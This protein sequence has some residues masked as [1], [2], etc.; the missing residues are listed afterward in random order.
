MSIEQDNVDDG[1]GEAQLGPPP[2]DARDA[3]IRELEARIAA[4]GDVEL[5]L[6][7]SEERLHQLLAERGHEEASVRTSEQQLSSIVESIVDGCFTLDGELRFVHINDAALSRLGRPRAAVIGRK[8]TE[9]IPPI[10]GSV[11][12]REYLAA[13]RTDKPAHFEAPATYL[14]AILAVHVYPARGQL[15]VLFQ[16]VSDRRR[17]ESDLREGERRFR[18]VFDNA[19][20]AIVLTDPSD[21]TGGV[22]DVNPAACRMFGYSADE[23]R[24]LRRDDI[25]DPADPATLVMLEERRQTGNASAV[26]RYKRKD[27]TIFAGEL[28][29]SLF[30]DQAGRTQNVSIIRDVSDR[31]AAERNE[32]QAHQRILEI[33]ESIGDGFLS[34]DHAWRFTFI[35]RRGAKRGGKEPNEVIGGNLWEFLPDIVGTE[36]ERSYR[37]AM[38]ER[39]PVCFE[40]HDV[41]SDTWYSTSVYPSH[42]GITMLWRDISAQKR[43]E[44]ELRHALA[45]AEEGQRTLEALMDSIPEGITIADANGPT[46]RMVSR[47]GQQLLGAP[48]AEMTTS[49]ITRR[50]TVYPVDDERPMRPEELPLVRAIRDGE[51]VRDAELIQKTVDGQRLRLSCNAAPIRDGKGRTLGGV[52]AWRDVTAERAS[53][54]ALRVSEQRYRDLFNSMTEGFAVHE[55]LCDAKGSPVDFRF[56]EI[57]PAF[58]RLTGLGRDIVGKTHNQV[59]PGDDP[60]WVQLYGNVA[61]TGQAT[62][63]E[64]YS[65]ALERHYKVMAFRPAPG[66]FATIFEDI[67]ERK[68][69]EEGLRKSEAQLGLLSRT[70]GQL[71]ASESPQ[72]TVERLCHDVMAHLGCD[73]FFN[74]L[75]DEEQGRLRLNACAGISAE[76]VGKIEWLDFGVAVCGC[77]ARS[78]ERIIVEDVAHSADPCV[79][80]I[81]SYGIQA[82]CCHPLIAGER[83]LG[84]LSFGTR[85]RAVFTDDEVEVMRTVA[86]QVATAMER[87]LS[88]VELS[89]ANAQLLQADQRK[90]EFLAVLSHELRNPLA[91]IKNS[92][93][94]LD[95]TPSDGE[96]ARRAK[97]VIERQ[98]THLSRLVDDLL[99]LTRVSRNKV[100][101]KREDLDLCELVGRVVEDQRSLFEQNEMSLT[102]ALTTAPLF[103]HGDSARLAQ[104]VSNI[105]QNAAKFTPRGGATTI[106]VERSGDRAIVRVR[107]NGVGMDQKTVAHLFQPFVQAD[108]TLD[109]SK[110]GLG[111]GLALVKGLVDMHAG[112]V[113]ARSDGMGKGSEF[114]VSLP[115]IDPSSSRRHRGAVPIAKPCRVLIIEDNVDAADSLREVLLMGEH[116]V[117]V[118][119]D[120]REGL[121]KARLFK[122]DIVLCDIGLPGMDGYEVARAFRAD[123]IL[124][125]THLLALSGYALPE[126]VQRAVDAGFEHHL[127]KP[128]SLQRIEELFAELRPPVL[129]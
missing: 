64:N 85:Q 87:M 29:T 20:D 119:Y 46:V 41:A 114:V 21:T 88:K 38:D 59:L 78:R 34:V 108:S 91:P 36:L 70:A 74:F 121:A 54:D 37:Q 99:D 13:L 3:R 127:A 15:T 27:G 63:F 120:G 97:Q 105:L 4:L 68:R 22:V 79:A 101:L 7:A 102:L 82:Y 75:V 31:Q 53:Q 94:I 77:V 17:M 48:H 98:V 60:A 71:L 117:E 5:R 28:T 39:V 8:I 52:V 19:T 44:E 26:L 32:R 84:T 56:L 2:A 40:H 83:L 110:G 51:T 118:A 125:T 49:E 33:I 123:E 67:T 62:Q 104:V 89:N 128:P 16:D 18:T 23:F 100:I 107:D 81:G 124:R 122:P 58:E 93:Y 106:S 115:A 10:A 92:I 111:L 66:R 11:F 113:N 86:D 30:L 96:Q 112:E 61:L 1:G 45:E 80:L 95:R 129:A 57:N 109:R 73:T 43:M 50:W 72:R 69:A 25:L 90:N 55:I 35:N 42:D 6:R 103:V 126:D 9:V 65:P 47:H 24:R 116:Q 14:D 12:E 76:D